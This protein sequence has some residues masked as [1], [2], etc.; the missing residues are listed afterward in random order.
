M[1]VPYYYH[2]LV[3]RVKEFHLIV[4]CNWFFCQMLQIYEFWEYE[5]F[6]KS[7]YFIWKFEHDSNMKVCNIPVSRQS[8]IYEKYQKFNFEKYSKSSNIC[9]HVPYG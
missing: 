2:N 6:K 3:Y 8:M 4:C 7:S 5:N 1:D 9:T